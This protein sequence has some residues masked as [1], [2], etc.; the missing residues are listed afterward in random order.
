[1]TK[2]PF[3]FSMENNEHFADG[4]VKSLGFEKRNI[5]IHQFPDDEISVSIDPEVKGRQVIF[6]CSLDRPNEKI[7]PLLFAADTARSLGATKI[8]LV[9]PYLAYMRQDMQFHPGEGISSRYFAKLISGN[10]DWIS[11]VDP[12]LHRYHSLSEI[13]AIPTYQLHA[14]DTLSVWLSNNITNAVLVGPD[15]ESTQWVSSLADKLNWPFLILHKIRK[16]DIDV[17][18][19]IP[20]IESYKNLTP[21]LIDDIISTA[22]TMIETVKRLHALKMQAPLC[23]GIHAVFSGNAYQDL[24]NAGVAKVA[25][26]NTIKHPSN[27]IDLTDLIVDQISTIINA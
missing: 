24:L 10:F 25:T 22:A 26:C 11:T 15:I 21:V 2:T 5:S 19:S 6:I 23:V 14:V 9:A 7:I 27:S 3:I 1:M 13:Y 20:Q 18:V 4:I 8:G 12:H 16:S 17:E